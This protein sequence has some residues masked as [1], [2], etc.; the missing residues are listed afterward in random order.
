MDIHAIIYVEVIEMKILPRLSSLMSAVPLTFPHQWFKE[1]DRLFTRF[2]W[3][4]KK[5]IISRKRLTIPR[6]KGGLSLI[7]FN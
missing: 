4:D 3:K 6:S 1:I 5:H 7:P 2:L